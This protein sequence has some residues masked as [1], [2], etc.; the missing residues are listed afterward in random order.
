MPLTL[1]DGVW[2][3]FYELAPGNVLDAH[4]AEVR[5]T[6]ANLLAEF[7]SVAVQIDPSSLPVTPTR[8][9]AL[10]GTPH[11]VGIDVTIPGGEWIDAR[12]L[13]AQR[14]IRTVARKGLRFAWL[15]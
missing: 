13:E 9:D 14:L 11:R 3:A 12:A 4:V 10:W 15:D 7:T 2:G 5:Q 1:A 6:L 8:R